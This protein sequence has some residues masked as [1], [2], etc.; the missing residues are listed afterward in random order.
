M[1]QDQENNISLLAKWL[2]SE[3]KAD[4]DHYVLVRDHLDLT[5]RE[6]R[7]LTTRL[8]SEIGVVEQKMCANEWDEI[9][10]DQVPSQA[11]NIYR[12]AF[13][14]HTPLQF[15]NWIDSVYDE[16]SDEE[17]NA[18]AIY[19]H[20]ITDRFMGRGMWGGGIRTDMSEDEERMLQA[21]WNNLPDHI[22]EGRNILPVCDTSGS[23]TQDHAINVSLGLGLYISERNKGPFK[24]QIVTFS[25][26]PEFVEI[27]SDDLKNRLRELENISW[28]SNTDFE[29]TV[30]TLLKI[31]NR[32]DVDPDVMPETILV[33]SDMQFDRCA[34][35]PSDSAMEMLEREYNEAGYE[36]PNLVFWNLRDS[37][38]QPVKFSDRGTALVS[39]FSPSILENVLEGENLTPISI[40][41]NTINSD[42]YQEVTL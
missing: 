21:Q 18:D 32:Y 39:G 7:K 26:S 27:E 40:A 42:R 36:L 2:P 37:S 4:H 13:E 12:N 16:D 34:R 1:S 30:H 41:M 20:Q 3:G 23:M 17:V 24:D 22:P 28:G 19:P 35:E 33:L 9:D 10:F 14:D 5:P 11:I 6:Y 15:K 31:A 38:G 29:K 25:G 8:R